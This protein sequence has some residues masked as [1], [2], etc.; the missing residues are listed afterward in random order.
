MSVCPVSSARLKVPAE[1]QSLLIITWV[2]PMAVL[3]GGA[4]SMLDGF[5]FALCR[6]G[7]VG[8]VS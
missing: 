2:P 5:T 7:G 8:P 4:E 3:P 1:K 6:P